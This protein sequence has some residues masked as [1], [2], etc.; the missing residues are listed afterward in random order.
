MDFSA[1]ITARTEDQTT[2]AAA[3]LA[4]RLSP[5]NV[6]LLRG[7]LGAGKT[8]FARAL[9]R[10]LCK[11]PA[12]EVPSPTFTLVQTYDSTLGLVW[13][14]DLYRL[15]DAEEIHELGWEEAMAGGITIVEWPE[16]LGPYIPAR[17]LDISLRAVDNEPNTRIIEITKV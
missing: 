1:P 12:L 8:L 16:R 7:N 14:F 2:A 17:H 11:D 9:L 5:G 6:L 15:K 13:H 3:A 4:V 10:T